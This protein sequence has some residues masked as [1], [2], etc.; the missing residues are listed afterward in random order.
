MLGFSNG[1]V[2]SERF[3]GSTGPIWLDQVSCDGSETDIA[4]CPH[5]TWGGHDCNH[6]DDVSVR[7][8]GSLT[9]PTPTA[10]W[11]PEGANECVE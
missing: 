9:D 5:S 7:C 3:T 11:P 6:S 4:Y 2:M 8:V 10:T 1:F